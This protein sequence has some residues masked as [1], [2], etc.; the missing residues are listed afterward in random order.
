MSERLSRRAAAPHRDV[1]EDGEN[2]ENVLIGRLHHRGA[3][4]SQLDDYRLHLQIGGAHEDA[5]RSGG[6][7]LTHIDWV[8]FPKARNG[9]IDSEDGARAADACRKRASRWPTENKQK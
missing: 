1:A 2:A 4:V 6:G 8:A 7:G 3:I 5:M 9:R